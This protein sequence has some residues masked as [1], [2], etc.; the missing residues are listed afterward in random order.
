M[1]KTNKLDDNLVLKK[2]QTLQYKQNSKD[3]Y[4]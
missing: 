2:L 4:L 1:D 3:K